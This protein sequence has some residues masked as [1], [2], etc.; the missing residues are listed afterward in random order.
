MR[1]EKD[2]EDM[3]KSCRKKVANVRDFDYVIGNPPL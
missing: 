1:E 2:L 3:L